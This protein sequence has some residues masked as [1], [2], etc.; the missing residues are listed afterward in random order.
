[1]STRNAP[2]PDGDIVASEY[3]KNPRR[4][5]K[6]VAQFF[7]MIQMATSHA[8]TTQRHIRAA[9]SLARGILAVGKNGGDAGDPRAVAFTADRGPAAQRDLAVVA[10]LA[11]ALAG[12]LAQA[13]AA[14]VRINFRGLYDEL[15]ERCGPMNERKAS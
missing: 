14:S 5:L 3:R 15:L 6:V 8:F 4:A 7:E 13:E 10:D 12:H 11:F 2:T 9:Q 1:M